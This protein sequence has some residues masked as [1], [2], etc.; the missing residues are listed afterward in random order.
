LPALPFI[1][2]NIRVVYM[3]SRRWP[4]KTERASRAESSGALLLLLLLCVCVVVVVVVVVGE[5]ERCEVYTVY[6][7]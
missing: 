7:E 3:P 2:F 6:D 4:C 1:K 5:R